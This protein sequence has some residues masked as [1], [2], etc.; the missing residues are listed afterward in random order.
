MRPGGKRL[1]KR[2]DDV[3]IQR[4]AG[5]ADFLRAIEDG[6]LLDGR[7]QRGA[8]ALRVPRPIERHVQH[9]DPLAVRVQPGGGL[10]EH[11]ERRADDDRDPLGLGMTAVAEQAV[12]AA[13]EGADAIHRALHDVGN[14]GVVRVRRLARLEKRVRVVGRAADDRPLRRERPRAVRAHQL[15]VD[16]G[17]DLLVRN[18]A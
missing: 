9:A 4:L 8:K 11:F 3:Q 16:R 17:P 5:S 18:D 12:G 10:V 13:G 1:G 6:D 15:V 2:R 7:R 14:A